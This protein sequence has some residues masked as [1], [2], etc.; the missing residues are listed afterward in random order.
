MILEKRI[1]NNA[2]LAEWFGIKESTFRSK[3][4]Q[5]LKELKEYADFIEVK[6]KIEVK[7]VYK[8]VYIKKSSVSFKKVAKL[9]EETWSKNGYDTCKNVSDKIVEC[10]DNELKK[11][12]PSTIY[13]YTR[14]AHIINYGSPA[15]QNGGV[16]GMCK[17]QWGKRDK[18]CYTQPLPF[19]KEESDYF[20]SLIKETFRADPQEIAKRQALRQAM[21][22]KEISKEEYF[23]LIDAMEEEQEG[24]WVLVEQGMYNEFGIELIRGTQ[25]K[26]LAFRIER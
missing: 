26:P 14:E 5:K 4:R 24:K 25:E 10:D 9:V 22:R 13:K 18:D 19:T 23:E 3:K 11:L 12:S 15:K 2:E 8:E 17:Y 20:Y 16:K 6:S 7:K 21:K 1:Y